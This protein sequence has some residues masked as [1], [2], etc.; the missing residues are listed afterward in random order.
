ML[1]L[2][3]KKKSMGHEVFRLCTKRKCDTNPFLECPKFFLLFRTNNSIL[4]L[5]SIGHDDAFIFN[6]TVN[7]FSVSQTHKFIHTQTQKYECGSEVTIKA[8]T[9][10][11]NFHSY[12]HLQGTNKQKFNNY[13]L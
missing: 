12:V 1:K 6:F 4:A 10:C 5:T 9:I 13:T 8:L 11:P 2:D 3:N 7:P